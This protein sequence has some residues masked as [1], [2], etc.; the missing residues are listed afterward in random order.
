[1]SLAA[2]DAGKAVLCEKPLTMTADE[3][4][5]LV[6]AAKAKNA[7]TPFSTTCATTRWCS[8]CGR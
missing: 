4:R 8:K 2:I 3:A 7:S 1:M 5:Q 6:D